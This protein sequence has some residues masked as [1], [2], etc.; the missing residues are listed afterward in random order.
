MMADGW[1]ARGVL[2]EIIGMLAGNGDIDVFAGWIRANKNDNNAL[3]SLGVYG[4]MHW[5]EEPASKEVYG[6]DGY[7][8]HCKI[9]DIETIK[10]LKKEWP[11]FYAAAFT[12]LDKDGKQ[13]DRKY[14]KAWFL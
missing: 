11:K 14:Q 12:A 1:A 8:S 3:K 4:P 5:V 2:T 9:D 13:V 7:F 10:K 6:Y